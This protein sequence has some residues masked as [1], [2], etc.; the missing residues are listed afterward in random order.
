VGFAAVRAE[1]GET[2]SVSIPVPARRLAYWDGAWVVE[3]GLYTL[4][5]GASATDVPL[6]VDWTVDA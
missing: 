4:R 5:V 2:A 6:R 3:P 1:A